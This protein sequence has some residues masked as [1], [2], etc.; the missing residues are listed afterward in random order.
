MML[1]MT[2]NNALAQ[3]IQE[4]RAEKG[5]TYADI[6]TRG[7][8]SKATVYKL[9]TKELDGLPRRKTLEALA[10]GLGLPARVVRE[11]AVKAASMTT[12]TED[13]S[14][15]EK[16]LIG[17]SRDL[18]DEQRRQILRLVEAMLDTD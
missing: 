12:Y 11:A 8:M 3:M 17:H 16:V 4:R 9:A 7:Q 15:W 13:M 6:A 10:R 2:K 1:A 18:T 14:E 5:W